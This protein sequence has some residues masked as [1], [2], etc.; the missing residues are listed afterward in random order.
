[1]GYNQVQGGVIDAGEVAGSGGLLFFGAQGEGVYVDT[2]VG[3]TGVVLEGLY[4]IEVVAQA[5]RE[6]VLAVQLQLGSY[7]R[8]FT[9]AVHVAG[10]FGDYVG[11]GIGGFVIDSGGRDVP[12]LG[13]GG[14]GIQS[15]GE[16]IYSV[17]VVERLGTV[18]GAYGG[19]GGVVVAVGNVF[20]GLYYP[21]EFLARVVEVQLNLVGRGANGFITSELNLF[22]QVFVGVLSHAAAFFG[23]QENVVYVQRGSYQGFVVGGGGA[24]G[25]VV[26]GPQAFSN[27]TQLQVDLDFVVLQSN[28]R[29]CQTGV[30]AEPELQGNIQSGFGQGVAGFAD[31]GDTGGI[32]RAIYIRVGGVSQVGQGGGLADH[33]LVTGFLGQTRSIG[34]DV[35]PVPYWRSMRWPPT[36]TST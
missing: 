7:Y 29:Q 27:G 14:E 28:Q 31:L 20:V 2:G 5:F 33:L 23:I 35:H 16:G 12:G 34:S 6:A 22:D 32:A 15:A 13:V 30:A 36:S 26:R 3:V 24:V 11:G 10:G 17:S 1:M 25:L 18:G 21:Y 9:P 8:V 4:N 19:T